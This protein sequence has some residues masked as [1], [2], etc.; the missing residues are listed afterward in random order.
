MQAESIAGGSTAGGSSAAGTTSSGGAS[1][2]GSNAGGSN[3][4]GSTAGG[5]GAG[6]TSGGASAGTTSSGGASAGAA[7]SSSCATGLTACAQTCVNLLT[8][9]ANCGACNNSC[10]TGRT[11]SNGGCQ[12]SGTSCPALPA[13]PGADGAAAGVSGG[14]GGSVCHVTRLDANYSDVTQGTL[15]YCL[16]NVTGKRTIVFDVS[17]VF[18]LG[19]TAVAGWSANGNGWDTASRLNIPADVTIAGQTAPGPVIIMGGVTKPGG[20]NIILRNVTFAPGYGVRGFDDVDHPRT[21]GDFPDSYVYDALDIAGQ[22]VII[23]H[24]TTV[25]ATDETVSMNELA[26]NITV[27]YSTIAQGQNY[28][29]ADAEASG[30]SYTGHAL[31]SL[32]QA[33]SGAKVSILHNF[34]AHLKGRLPRVGTES[35]AL[36]TA[37]LGPYNDFRNNVFY[38]WLSTAG[39]GASGQ[40]S[41][42]NFIGNF[43][44]AGDG[45]DNPVGGS[46]TDV[47]TA[48]GGT[49]IFS[50]SDATNIKV[51][52]A[53]NLKDVNKDADAIDT[54]AL[55]SSDF[56]TSS[57]QGSAY[58][59]TP[60]TGVTDA[61]A[62]AFERV[63]NYAGAAWWDRSALDKRLVAEARDGSGKIIAWADN[64]F[65]TSASEGTEWRSLVATPLKERPAG[66]DTDGDG[67]PDAWETAH[68]LNS[69]VAD[70][71]GDFDNDGYTNLEE[72]I[73]ELAAWPAPAQALFTGQVNERFALIGNWT[74]APSRAHL[75]ARASAAWQPSRYDTAQI[76]AG[77][78]LVDSVGQHARSLEIA[79]APGQARLDIVGGW[80]DVANRVE[81]GSYV[82]SERRRDSR[83]A[84][85][86]ELNQ[87]GGT[88]WARTA[89]LLAPERGSSAVY[90]LS[91]GL[92]ST[93]RLGQG[94]GAGRFV[95]A[96]GTLEAGQVDFALA[97]QGGVLSPGPGVADA[98]L[99]ADL[100]LGRGAL[101]IELDAGRSDRVLVRGR[102][103]L[104]GA[105][106]VELA[107]GVLPREGSVWT[108]L[109]AGGG[110]VGSFQEVPAG[111]AVEVVGRRVL[112]RYGASR[113]SVAPAAAASKKI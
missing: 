92:L 86:A 32:F 105:L 50:G 90:N 57:I 54:T 104:G 83:V 48:A 37:G 102:A 58:T 99:L 15:R 5:A 4:G 27:Q 64:P 56:A 8:D 13:F 49:A 95:F 26:N 65:D 14:R 18:S 76:R 22:N 35:G 10:G 44:L 33:G 42:N 113:I 111:F 74:I 17:G 29:Q 108:I 20:T 97:N 59:Q 9:N 60:Y 91:G 38:N 109:E 78:A 6:G 34:Y 88:L 84:G 63:L 46:S 30:V 62:A 110:V 94:H 7:G 89:L 1:T 107:Q 100:N 81:L 53:S 77:R 11:C 68:S 96:G 80:L 40:F 43:Y 52:Q 3:A 51:Y 98:R 72:Y 24:V 73:N 66:F 103:K 101:L 25:Y 12:C 71:N 106:R 75:G 45:G 41:Q 70:N 67:M 112:L 36:T 39:T 61:P 19:R 55:T 87:S 23:D 69:S 31:G 2:G 85:H 28:P 79:G 47:T 93:P 82:S 16:Q 21:V